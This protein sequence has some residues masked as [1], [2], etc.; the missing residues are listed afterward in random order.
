[1]LSLVLGVALAQDS[2]GVVDTG[3]VDTGVVVDDTGGPDSGGGAV[4]TGGDS[5]GIGLP[6]LDG[7]GFSAL[8]D[9]DDTDASVNPAA[10]ELC[11]GVDND[12]DGSV[13]EAD[14]ADAGTWYLDGD[15]DGYGDPSFPVTACV[16]PSGSSTSSDDCDDTDAA[17]NP[18]ATEVWY[19]GVDQDCD[20]NDADQDGDGHDAEGAGGDDCDDTDPAIYTGATDY[21][22]DGIDADCGGDSDYDADGDG[23]DSITYGGDDCDDARAEVYPGATDEPYDGDVTDCDASDEYDV[24]GD[25]YDSAE[26]GGNDC[27]DGDSSL[28]PGEDEVWYDGVDQDCDGNDDDQDGD[29]YSVDDDCDDTDA[30]SYPGAP[31]WSD[32]CEE[33]EVVDTAPPGDDTGEPTSGD[34]GDTG[35]AFYPAETL[36][37][38]GGAMCSGSGAAGLAWLALALLA[39]LRRRRMI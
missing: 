3:G 33:V 5:G 23:Y 1:M 30:D 19:D 25:G 11:D 6:D 12:C 24:D 13:D 7:D 16:Q 18:G 20:D 21:W 2:G 8:D 9:C 15:G 32:D 39:P 26:Y 10:T 28:N 27:D 31:G 29:G 22:Y 38:G 37:G 17:I 36:S 4:D 14:A 35:A 34:T